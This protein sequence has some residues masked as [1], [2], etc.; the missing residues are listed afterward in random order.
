MKR[1]LGKQIVLVSL[2]HYASQMRITV[3]ADLC[4]SKS[5]NLISAQLKGFVK[6]L[7]GLPFNPKWE[8]TLPE[9]SNNKVLYSSKVVQREAESI[10]D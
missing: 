10:W 8:M 3:K 2:S 6:D 1:Y 4:F 9:S 5:K 7:L